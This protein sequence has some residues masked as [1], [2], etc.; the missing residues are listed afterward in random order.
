[1]IFVFKTV[2]T[3]YL[4]NK[5]NLAQN[6]MFL[7]YNDEEIAKNEREKKIIESQYEIT[8]YGLSRKLKFYLKF[9]GAQNYLL[10]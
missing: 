9:N 8:T 1:M 6:L 2:V 3:Q 4:E 5:Y 7:I 10:H